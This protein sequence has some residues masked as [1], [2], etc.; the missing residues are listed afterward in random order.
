M[1]SS[2]GRD[3]GSPRDE[4]VPRRPALARRRRTS[5]LA[6]GAVGYGEPRQIGST[7][8]RARCSP[9]KSG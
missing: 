2:S 6:V 4:S 7:P 1:Y 8:K 5:M 3:A 9:M